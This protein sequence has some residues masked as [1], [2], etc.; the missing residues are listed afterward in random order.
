MRVVLAEDDLATSVLLAGTLKR[1]GYEVTV[2]HSGTE[3]WETLQRVNEPTVAIL[4]WMMPGL[5]GVEVCRRVREQ[6]TE[7][8]DYIYVILLT[9]RATK[10]NL[11]EGMEAGAD[12]YVVKPCDPQELR[13]RVR[14]GQRIVELH[15]A[16]SE[17]KKHLQ[18]L[19]TTDALTGVL[20]RRA[21]LDRIVQE[22]SRAR[23]QQSSLSLAMMDVDHFKTINDTYGHMHGDT[24]LRECTERAQTALR[25]YDCLGRLGGEEFLFVFP[26]AALADAAHVAER[27]RQCLCEREIALGT[28]RVTV[29]ASLGVAQWDGESGMDL[30]LSTVDQAMYQAKARGRNRVF[31]QS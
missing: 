14:A 16:L 27:I 26:G 4:D 21:I 15:G 29:T 31:F 17:A 30:L 23:R 28:D 18:V 25:G 6:K 5:E 20:N 13:V 9:S 1:W 2:V 12:D 7:N 3:A 22:M 10:E 8:G 19:A 24:V 11:V